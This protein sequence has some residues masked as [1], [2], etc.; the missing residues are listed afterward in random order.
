MSGCTSNKA[1]TAAAENKP[2]IDVIGTQI[3]STDR[4]KGYNDLDGLA[5][6]SDEIFE[7]TVQ[8]VSYFDKGNYTFSKLT[9]KVTESYY[10]DLKPGD[11]VNVIE[12]GGYTTAENYIKF[13]GKEKF[14]NLSDE[15]AS[16][17]YVKILFDGSDLTQAGENLLLFTCRDKKNDWELPDDYLFTV[18]YNH[19]KFSIEAD[20]VLRKINDI[21]IDALKMSKSDYKNT[22]KEKVI[23]NKK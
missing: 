4:N 2:D 7:G 23:Q 11:S 20:S 21:S 6:V 22:I 16:K 3:S 18:G 12:P 1:G 5:A 17:K 8:G 10:G 19:G 13:V 15:E 9:I 14:P